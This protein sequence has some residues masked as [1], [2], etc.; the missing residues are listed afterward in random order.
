MKFYV[1]LFTCSVLL[2]ACK[3][4]KPADLFFHNAHIYVV[5][6]DFSEATSMVISDHKVVEV[7]TY[8]VLKEKYEAKE[9][10]DLK[11][12]T[13]LPGLYDAHAHFYGLGLQQRKVNL[14]GTTSWE[15]VLERLIE[16]KEKYNPE[17]ITGRGWDQNDWENTAFPDNTKLSELFPN[18]PVLIRRV[19]GHA[20][21]ANKRAI[22]Q[23]GITIDTPYSGGEIKQKNGELTGLFIDNPLELVEAIIP[24]PNKKDIE[25]ALKDAEEIC[26]KH[27]LTSVVD[28][29]LNKSVLDEIFRLNTE[30]DINL[31]LMGSS[32]DPQ[33]NDVLKAGFQ[34]T[35]RLSLRSIKCYADGA[36]GSRGACLHEAYSDRENHYGALLTPIESFKNIAKNIHQAGFQM[37]THAIGDS[38]NSV[39]LDIYLNTLENPEQARWR[40]EHAQV[41][42]EEDLNKFKQGI[43]PSVQPTHATSDMYWAKDRLGE[44]RMPLAYAYKTLLNANGRI[45]LG[46]DFPIERV[47]PF[48]TFYSAVARKDLKHYPK[49]GF[50][51]KDALTREEALKGM[52]IWAAYSC[53]QEAERGSLEKGKYADFIVI[54]RNLMTCS[55]DSIPTTQVLKTFIKGKEVYTNVR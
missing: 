20:L 53:F 36:L 19:D 14:L 7:G 16:F 13:I 28:A 34:K 10:I 27:G 41:L 3:E 54:D 35:E 38:A 17:F 50:Q 6:K 46:T 47:N 48:H 42:K 51:I 31:Y 43:I 18:T 49:D 8:S 40:I 32:T 25:H 37:N 2:M 39:V 1:S 52:T 9:V 4:K 29:G 5:D 55:E 22:K 15:N 30:M 21:I 26:L 23:A 44:K 12:K 24:E 11:G 33:L 45:A